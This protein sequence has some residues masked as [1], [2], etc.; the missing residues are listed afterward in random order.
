MPYFF[1][2][3]AMGTSHASIKPGGTGQQIHIGKG[4]RLYP[5]TIALSGDPTQLK[6]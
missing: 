4:G 2:V 5:W 6:I 3:L 1:A